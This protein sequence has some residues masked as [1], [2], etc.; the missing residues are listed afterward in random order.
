ME[1]VHAATKDRKA[2]LI[3]KLTPNVDNIGEIAKAVIDAGADGIAAINTVGPKLYIEPDSGFPILNNKVGGKGG[4]SGEWVKDRAIECIRG[5]RAAIGDEPIILGM[6][7][8]S[9]AEDAVKMIEAG[10]D[11]V[12]IGSAL[13]RVEPSEWNEYLSRIKN[14][15]NTDK[16]RK[17]AM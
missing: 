1:R 4:A 5:I 7:G 16:I 15:E 17:G 11:S 13:S 12:G 2:L 3:I 9:K 6:G 8:V 10:A 14:G